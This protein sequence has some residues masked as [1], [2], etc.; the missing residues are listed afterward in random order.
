MNSLF[1]G[2]TE[3]VTDL[4]ISFLG[5]EKRFHLNIIS[6]GPQSEGGGCHATESVPESALHPLES[7]FGDG[8]F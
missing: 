4:F 5:E 7:A 6:M 2:N 8:F 1:I 3:A